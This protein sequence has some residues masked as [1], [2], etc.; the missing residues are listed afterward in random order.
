MMQEWINPEKDLG[1]VEGILLD[2]KDII[3]ESV[4]EI[5]RFI[6]YR[7]DGERVILKG[8]LEMLY[9]FEIIKKCYQLINSKLDSI[10]ETYS[11]QLQQQSQVIEAL[12]TIENNFREIEY[13]LSIINELLSL[14]DNFISRKES[15]KIAERKSAVITTLFNVVQN[16][17]D[18]Y[19]DFWVKF[20]AMKR[21]LGYNTNK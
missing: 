1:N 6:G 3:Q 5:E 17:K 15:S 21:V 16:V 7:L 11:K 8:D 13:Y 2:L 4:R 18:K 20:L 12:N 10:E 19:Q 9:R 14:I